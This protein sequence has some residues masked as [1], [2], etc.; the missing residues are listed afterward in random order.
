MESEK[1]LQ[2]SK[3]PLFDDLKKLTL[4]EGEYAVFGS[5]PLW[6]RGIREAA[7]IDIIARG[8]AWEAVRTKGSVQ[9]KKGLGIQYIP[10]ANG[11]IEI[12]KDWRPGEWNVDELIETAEIIDGI[13][14]VRLDVVIEWKKRR[15]QEKDLKDLV[16]IEEYLAHKN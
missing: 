9:T 1:Y 7:D 5:G 11:A 16:L 8:K 10:F 15:G 6:V 4:P 3:H 12:Y 13:P 14:F 2:L